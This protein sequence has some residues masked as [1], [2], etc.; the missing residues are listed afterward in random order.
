[1]TW[2]VPGPVT[3]AQLNAI[4]PQLRERSTDQS[5]TSDTALAD[6]DTLTFDVEADTTYL[7]RFWLGVT[8]GSAG[9][10]KTRWSVPAGTTGVLRWC[11]GPDATTGSSDP[12]VLPA[13]R[14]SVSQI[15]SDVTYALNSTT[16]YAAIL[17]TA[18]VIVGSTAGT[19]TIRHA[20]VAS[21]A[22]PTVIRAGSFAECYRFIA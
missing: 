4:I 7:V 9:D 3:S 14:L 15:T 18:K 1:M 10:L 21:S 17:E 22:T 16:N 6:D 11:L 5:Y 12:S 13:V 2:F 20:Q 8:G 19:I